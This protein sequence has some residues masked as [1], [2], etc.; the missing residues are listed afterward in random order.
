MRRNETNI[1]KPEILGTLSPH[2]YLKKLH[3]GTVSNAQYYMLAVPAN[4]SK[5]FYRKCIKTFHRKWTRT[6][7]RIFYTS[8]VE[9]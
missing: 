5:T 6:Y 9:T 4:L 3:N 7:K 8:I 1:G 2:K